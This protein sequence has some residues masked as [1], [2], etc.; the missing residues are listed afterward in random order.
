MYILVFV[1]Y[2]KEVFIVKSF[3]SGSRVGYSLDGFIGICIY[4]LWKYTDYGLWNDLFYYV[5]V[6]LPAAGPIPGSGRSFS[7]PIT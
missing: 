6:E 5:V 7:P 1:E 4:M 2:Y 3:R